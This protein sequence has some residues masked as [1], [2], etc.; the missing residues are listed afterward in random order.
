MENEMQINGNWGL[1]WSKV[2]CGCLEEAGGLCLSAGGPGERT[3]LG[4]WGRYLC[5]L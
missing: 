2:D 4:F 1:P 3:I 5:V